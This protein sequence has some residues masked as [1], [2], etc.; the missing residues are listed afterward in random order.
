M[1][2]EICKRRTL[3][4]NYQTILLFKNILYEWYIC[5]PVVQSLP[6]PFTHWLTYSLMLWTLDWCYS[7][8]WNACSEIVDIGYDVN[9]DVSDSLT[10]VGGNLALSWWPLGDYCEINLVDAWI[11]LMM[12]LLQL[13]NSSGWALHVFDDSLN[14]TL[15][16][17]FLFTVFGYW[18]LYSLRIPFVVILLVNSTQTINPWT[19]CDFCNVF[20]GSYFHRILNWCD[21]ISYFHIVV[22]R[23]STQQ[24]TRAFCGHLDISY[25]GSCITTY[26]TNSLRLSITSKTLQKILF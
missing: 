16:D 3:E 23:Q 20:R 6:S 10:T 25:Y 13:D 4:A 14:T 24:V 18:L 9:D 12:A 26:K 11:C 17:F 15:W 8:R 21:R 7:G 1:K 5:H 2:S 22:F 19:R